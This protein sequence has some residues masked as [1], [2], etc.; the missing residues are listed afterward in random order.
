MESQHCVRAEQASPDF[1]LAQPEALEAEHSN[2]HQDTHL[3]SN[4]GLNACRQDPCTVSTC[5]FEE[6][7][8][9][10]QCVLCEPFWSEIQGCFFHVWFLLWFYSIA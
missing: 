9:I 1:P 6:R 4:Q 7:Q 8:H 10:K 3:L 5:C 2:A